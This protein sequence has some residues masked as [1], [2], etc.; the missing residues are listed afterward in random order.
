LINILDVVYLLNSIYKDGPDP[1]CIV[2]A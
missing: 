1:E 2:W